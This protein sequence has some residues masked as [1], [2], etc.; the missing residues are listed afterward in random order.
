MQRQV[1]V[2]GYLLPREV[3]AHRLRLG[4]L[5]DLHQTE[6]EHVIEVDRG[7]FIDVT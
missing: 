3:D 4:D 6:S 7:S 2:L 5:P 1:G